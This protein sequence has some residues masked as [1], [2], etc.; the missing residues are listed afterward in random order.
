MLL[1]YHREPCPSSVSHNLCT[2]CASATLSCWSLTPF[3]TLQSTLQFSLSNPY[4]QWHQS[5]WFSVN[6]GLKLNQHC[7]LWKGWGGKAVKGRVVW[8]YE[9]KAGVRTFLFGF[10]ELVGVNVF[11][12]VKFSCGGVWKWDFMWMEGSLHGT[13]HSNSSLHMCWAMLIWLPLAYDVSL[14][15]IGDHNH[16]PLDN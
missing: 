16:W 5:H 10:L 14:S 9:G 3:L 2:S 12:W 15:C 4:W 6:W 13:R 8:E 1:V 7:Q 11:F